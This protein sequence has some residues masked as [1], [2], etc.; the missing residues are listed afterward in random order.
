MVAL[1]YISLQWRHNESD[2]VPNHRRLDCLLSCLF[3]RRSKKTS[4]L[5]VTG[6]CGGNTLVTGGPSHKGPVTR[7][8]FPHDDGIMFK[9]LW[10]SDTIWR[11]RSWSTFP[12]V[13]A[14]CLTVPSH[15]LNQ[16]W[17][18]RASGIH[19]RAI[20]QEIPQPLITEI[21]LK[22]IYVKFHSDLPGDSESK[23]PDDEATQKHWWIYLQNWTLRLNCA[24]VI[25]S[26]SW[27]GRAK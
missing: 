22:I 5:R 10:P 18:V 23:S 25:L 14:C 9:S 19:L 11:Q 26:L 2:S 8:V 24:Q 21:R 15:Y 16:C 27:T 13:M 4:K 12:Q 6:L 1:G 17:L 3:I 7:K 20:S